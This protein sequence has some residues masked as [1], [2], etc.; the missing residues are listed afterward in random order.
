M[1]NREERKAAR[2]TE[3]LPWDSEWLGFPVA[4]VLDPD[5]TERELMRSLALL[6]ERKTRLV[7]WN[8][9]SEGAAV[10]AP[11]GG[12]LVDHKT[13]FALVELSAARQMQHEVEAFQ[14]K[15]PDPDLLCLALE[16]GHLSRFHTDPRIPVG[17]ADELYRRW[18]FNALGDDPDQEALVIRDVSGR[19]QGMI[20]LSQRSDR[21]Q[22][23]LIAVAGSARG[24]GLGR[25]LVEA[26]IDWTQTRALPELR[27]VTQGANLPACRLYESCGFRHRKVEDVYHFWL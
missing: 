18:L 3:L 13:T 24:Q 19:I 9:H 27:V 11:A 15:K 14:G 23:E 8:T 25:S 20:T 2:V 7:Y 12:S 4:R 16:S 1:P 10:A 22:I 17:A 5:L 26:A 6:R 21:A